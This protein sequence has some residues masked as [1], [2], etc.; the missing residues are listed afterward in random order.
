[1]YVKSEYITKKDENKSNLS[2]ITNKKFTEDTE[3]TEMIF[4][5]IKTNSPILILES[6][7]S[8]T[9][10]VTLTIIVTPFLAS[11]KCQYYE[12]A[13]YNNFKALNT[14]DSKKHFSISRK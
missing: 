7:H 10:I 14:I 2:I 1:M 11:R 4:W 8:I 3:Y 13:Q 6:I 9:Q 12:W 5:K